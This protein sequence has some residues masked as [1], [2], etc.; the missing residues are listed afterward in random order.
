MPRRSVR[1]AVR[2]VYPAPSPGAPALGQRSVR[3]LV[4]GVEV[5]NRVLVVAPARVEL[6]ER[7]RD[8]NH[9]TPLEVFAALCGYVL[10]GVHREGRDVWRAQESPPSRAHRNRRA[11][12]M[13]TWDANVRRRRS[14]RCAYAVRN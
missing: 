14:F 1:V 10:R 6:G 5:L 11:A 7:E 12:S 4:R 3:E 8:V 2:G 13:W 9:R